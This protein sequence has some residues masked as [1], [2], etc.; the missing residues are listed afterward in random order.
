LSFFVFL[1]FLFFF[2]A[3]LFA[4]RRPGKVTSLRRLKATNDDEDNDY[5]QRWAQEYIPSPSSFLLTSILAYS[6]NYKSLSASYVANLPF[7]L[8][9][10]LYH[11]CETSGKCSSLL[12]KVDSNEKNV[13]E[14]ATAT[15]KRVG[16]EEGDELSSS[17]SRKRKMIET[18]PM[19]GKFAKRFLEGDGLMSVGGDGGVVG[20]K[21]MA[22]NIGEFST[23]TVLLQQDIVKLRLISQKSLVS[24]Q[25]SGSAK[26][27]GGSVSGK[28]GAGDGFTNTTKRLLMDILD[29]VPSLKRERED[30]LSFSYNSNNALDD[31]YFLSNVAEDPSLHGGS[32]GAERG[33]SIHLARSGGSNVSGS[34]EE[35][36]L[37]HNSMSTISSHR[38][39]PSID[40]LNRSGHGLPSTNVGGNRRRDSSSTNLPIHIEGISTEL[41]LDMTRQ[42]SLATSPT[43]S[44]QQNTRFYSDLINEK[45]KMVELFS[46]GSGDNQVKFTK[47]TLLEFINSHDSLMNSVFA[48]N[49]SSLSSSTSY[50]TNINSVNASDPNSNNVSFSTIPGVSV[51]GGDLS[52]ITLFSQLK[53]SVASSQSK[54]RSSSAGSFSSPSSLLGVP[55]KGILKNTSSSTL[56]TLESMNQLPPPPCASLPVNQQAPPSGSSSGSTTNVPSRAHDNIKMAMLLGRSSAPRM[57]FTPPSLRSVPEKDEKNA[58]ADRSFGKAA[59]TALKGVSVIEEEKKPS[60]IKREIKPPSESADAQKASIS[61]TV[62]ETSTQQ[63]PAL[64]APLPSSPSRLPLLQAGAGKRGKLSS[65]NFISRNHILRGTP[66]T[67]KTVDAI[68]NEAAGGVNTEP[69]NFI[70]EH[71]K[72]VPIPVVDNAKKKQEEL[73]EYMK[74]YSLQ[75]AINPFRQKEG[76]KYLKMTTH[77][78]RRWSHV[79][80]SSKPF[81][82][83]S[84]I[85]SF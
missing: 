79:F 26:L 18:I 27:G 5:D 35:R 37:I 54:E 51:V 59:T 34:Y 69:R 61:L 8:K 82:S 76:E 53:D 60:S 23:K 4:T 71:G 38:H 75:Y 46:S 42:S 58:S 68:Y 7:A 3:D 74:N 16:A 36:R 47:D 39:R 17:N 81:L 40:E 10:L 48:R 11:M 13:V 22:N 72:I 29:S 50:N 83:F 78:R 44:Q 33:N 56:Q 1:C 70:I 41:R 28:G 49:K 62:N 31:D 21:K 32:F 63:P 43:S 65:K 30:S 57:M 14:E 24:D 52:T 25:S 67:L 12:I 55:T 20:S 77:N 85:S 2:F 19:W 6:P 73:I 64:Q 9:E 66:R 84:V 80:P 15:S 45:R